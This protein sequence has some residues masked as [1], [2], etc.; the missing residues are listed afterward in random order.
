[1]SSDRPVK[2]QRYIEGADPDLVS[3]VLDE[4]PYLDFE[5]TLEFYDH[6]SA[7]VEA[8]TLGL[9]DL[10]FIG[11]NDRYFLLT[12]ILQRKD[13]LH[14]WLFDRCREVEADPDGYLDLWGRYHFKSSIITYGGTIQDILI[15]PDITQCIFSVTRPNARKFLAQIKETLERNELLKQIYADCLWANPRKQAPK[16]SLDTGIVVRRSASN[17][18][19]EATVEANGL[20]EGLPAGPH[21]EKLLYDDVVTQR[22]VTN[23]EMIEKVSMHEEL[24]DNLGIGIKTRKQ[25]VGTRYSHGDSYQRIIDRGD[26][27]LRIYP[28]THNGKLTGDPVFLTKAAWTKVKRTQKKVVAAQHLMNPAAGSEASFDALTFR[29]YTVRPSILNVYIMGDPSGGKNYRRSDRTAIA[30]IGIDSNSNF[31]LL[32]GYRHRMKLTERWN[33]LHDLYKKWF[34]MPGIQNVEVGYEQYALQADLQYF[35]EQ[36]KKRDNLSFAI[37]ELNWPR[38]GEHS[39]VDRVERLEPYLRLSQFYFPGLV[40]HADYS[41]TRKRLHAFWEVNEETLEID[42][43]AQMGETSAMRLMRSQQ[44]EWRIVRPIIRRDE[45]NN[46]YDL[47]RVTLEELRFFPFGSHDDIADAASRIFDMDWNPPALHEAQAIETPIYEDT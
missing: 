31:Y 13:A 32:D 22:S 15:D 35:E 29:P 41:E 23:P 6:V 40:W 10:A 4:L 45:N 19:K 37:E 33:R 30:V 38:E 27:K 5:E 43:R 2:G 28:T 47:T 25:Y 9:N 26:V 18:K 44:Q 39:K 8:L 3:F 34:H 17:T 42:Y 7:C 1:M 24:S 16:W 12:A 46:L 20:V 11:C 36:M 21:F 14:P